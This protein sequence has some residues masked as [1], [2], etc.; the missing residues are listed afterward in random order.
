MAKDVYTSND[1][2]ARRVYRALKTPTDN[3]RRTDPILAF[4]F[5]GKG[6]SV[7]M[8]CNKQPEIS[9]KG[10]D[11]T[12]GEVK[13]FAYS[14]FADYDESN[15]IFKLRDEITLIELY[16]KGSVEP[17]QWESWEKFT[18][19]LDGLSEEGIQIS[20]KL[21]CLVYEAV[22]KQKPSMQNFI[23]ESIKKTLKGRE[24]E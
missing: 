21:P 10:K 5:K 14:D 12:A 23:V 8:R 20:L 22:R 18:R 4:H 1:L 9:V 15:V 16:G 3:N 2:L 17:M 13:F 19:W 7:I 24:R 6:D 11:Q